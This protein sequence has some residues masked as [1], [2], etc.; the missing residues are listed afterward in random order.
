M[1]ALSQAIRN[2]RWRQA[3]LLIEAG[4]DINRRCQTDGRTALMEVCFLDDEDKAF[5][6]AKILLE[7]G[8]ELGF[9]DAK[10]LN[11]LSY[12]CILK[13]K[14]LVTL[15][16]RFVDY[17][18]NAVDRDANTALFH[19]IT[20]GDLAIVKLLVKKLKY[21]HLSVDTQNHKG[22]T[23]LI[24]ALKIGNSQCA[25]FLIQEGKAS[26]EIRDFE[27]LKSATQWKKELQQQGKRIISAFYTVDNKQKE[28]EKSTRKI[29][30]TVSAKPTQVCSFPEINENRKPNA[31]RPLTAPGMIRVPDFFTPCTPVQEELLQLYGIYNQQTSSSYRKGYK[32]TPKAVKMLP[33]LMEEVDDEAA[34]S[35]PEETPS[36]QGSRAKMN[37]A[38]VNELN[39]KIKGL[40]KAVKS[41]KN[42]SSPAN[43]EAR[44]KSGKMKKIAKLMRKGESKD[45]LIISEA[46]LP[47]KKFD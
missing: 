9:Q 47:M 42:S 17:N 20:V 29:R 15:F 3:R 41:R 10:G 4:S 12:A 24:H 14:K 13:R 44:L 43:S 34:E 6:L 1:T 37:F 16:L 11:A 36:E 46:S 2:K 35:V 32:F 22:E 26:L 31:G 45:S 5:G 39:T 38:Q 40:Q 33:P 27:Q 7:N 23:P 18:L 25:D 30:K 21:Y 8:A 19:A 28:D